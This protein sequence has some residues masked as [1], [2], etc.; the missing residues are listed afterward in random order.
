M[1]Q[2]VDAAVSQ[3][4]NGLAVRLN[5][6]IARTAGMAEG[7]QV[8]IT[9]EKG[10]IVLEAIEPGITLASMLAAFDPERHGGEVMIS[11][12]VGEEFV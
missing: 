8:R 11:P 5:K 1:T 2:T 12:P 3:W 6:R 4:G 9:A 7:T 10:R